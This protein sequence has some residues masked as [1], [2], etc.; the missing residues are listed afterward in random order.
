MTVD[1]SGK[2]APSDY[3]IYAKLAGLDII[4]WSFERAG[5][6]ENLV[7]EGRQYYYQ[8]VSEAMDKDGDMYEVLDVLGREIGVLGVFSDW[9]ASVSYYANCMKL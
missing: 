7:E 3:A 5:P 2:I 1:E 6:I 4:A 9:P 8:S